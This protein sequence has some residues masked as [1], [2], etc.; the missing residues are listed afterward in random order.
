M[1]NVSETINKMIETLPESMQYSIL[2]DL[3]AIIA[4]KLDEAQWDAKFQNNPE[5]LVAVAKKVKKE[6]A[7][8]KPKPMDKKMHVQPSNS[9]RILA[10]NGA[11]K[12][13]LTWTLPLRTP[14]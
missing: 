10:G 14:K 13:S 11:S 7:G 2:N 9:E 8:G 12:S 5:A 1:G 3:K 4:E 6:I